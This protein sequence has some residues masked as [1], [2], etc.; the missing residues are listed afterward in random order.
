MKVNKINILHLYNAWYKIF[1]E[2]II[3]YIIDNKYKM[4]NNVQ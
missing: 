4:C 2:V 3:L 1:N